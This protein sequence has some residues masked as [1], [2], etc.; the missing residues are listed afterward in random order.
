MGEGKIIHYGRICLYCGKEIESRWDDCDQ[1]YECDC[2]DAKKK[3][4]IEKQIR[5]LEYKI[6]DEKFSLQQKY[7]LYEND[8]E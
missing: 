2:P 7:V 3:R 1:Y 4:S 5:D 6:P 8:D